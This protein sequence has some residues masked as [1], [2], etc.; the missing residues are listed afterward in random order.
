V[1]ALRAVV[2]VPH[3]EAMAA[4][5]AIRLR[6]DPLVARLPA[7]VTLVFLFDSDIGDDALRSHVK[8]SV[9]AASPFVLR[10]ARIIPIDDL[11]LGVTITTGSDSTVELHDRLYTG[12]LAHHLSEVHR[13]VPH[14]TIGRFGQRSAMEPRCGNCRRPR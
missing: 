9:A 1:N 2:A 11:H 8:R 5:E 3:G 7:H 4:I 13:F 12:P 14:V 6:H 10:L